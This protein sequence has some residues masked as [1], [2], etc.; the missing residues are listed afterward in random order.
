MGEPYTVDD[1]K[2]DVIAIFRD[3]NATNE[4]WAAMAAILNNASEGSEYDSDDLICPIDD[5]VLGKRVVC[6]HCGSLYRPK[7]PCWGC[8]ETR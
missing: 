6:K 8:G 5:A 7:C 2:R 1:Y 4:Q 3:G